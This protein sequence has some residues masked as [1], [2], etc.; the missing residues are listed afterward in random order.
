MQF[1]QI[2]PVSYCPMLHESTTNPDPMELSKEGHV[3]T[4]ED[5]VKLVFYVL[6]KSKYDFLSEYI[7]KDLNKPIEDIKNRINFLSEKDVFDQEMRNI[8]KAYC[9][10][11]EIEL[12]KQETP[13][14]K[15]EDIQKSMP[16]YLNDSK[17]WWADMIIEAKHSHLY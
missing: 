10:E 13:A 12:F 5:D 9:C 11:I 6:F 2:E 15:I 14:T 8:F 4:V 1:N 3:W 17:K 16:T 7:I